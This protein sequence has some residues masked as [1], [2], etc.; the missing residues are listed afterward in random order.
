MDNE[1]ASRILKAKSMNE[2]SA[3]L[4]EIFPG[5]LKVPLTE[6]SK[7]A[8]DHILKLMPSGYDENTHMD[9]ALKDFY[10]NEPD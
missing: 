7:E 4:K 5:E 9:Y 2:V 8:A 6:F 3:I 1:A 10:R